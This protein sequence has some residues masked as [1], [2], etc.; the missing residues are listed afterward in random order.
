ML[1]DVASNVRQALPARPPLLAGRPP[2]ANSPER[3]V[4][5]VI[6][7][8]VLLLEGSVAFARATRGPAVLGR[9]GALLS[10]VPPTTGSYVVL[11]SFL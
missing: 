8:A 9:A 6:S 3:S 1:D 4:L 2:L 7:A 5:S 10:P 11:I